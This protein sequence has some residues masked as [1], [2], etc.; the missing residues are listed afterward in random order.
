MRSLV[1][2]AKRDM[3]M[4][5]ACIAAVISCFIVPPDAQYVGYIDF[6]TLALLFC[7]MLVVAGFKH[8]GLFEAL[9]GALVSRITSPRGIALALVMLCFFGSTLITNDVSLITFVPFAMLVLKMTGLQ[10]Q[11]YLTVCLMTIAANLGSMLTPMGNP[12]N[13]YLYASSEYGLTDFILLMLPYFVAA[14]LLLAACTFLI[15]NDDRHDDT[16]TSSHEGS[17]D[18][19][20][21]RSL[22]DVIGV[23]L[24]WYAALF[25]LCLFAVAKVLPVWILLII[26]C[27]AIAMKRRSLLRNVDYGLLATFVFFFVFVGNMSRIDAINTWLSTLMEQHA[28]TVSILSSQVISNVPA[29]VLL[30]HY[31]SDVA[32][33]IIGTNLGGLGT[34]IASMASLISYKQIAAEYPERKGHY[35]LVFTVWNVIFLAVLWGMAL[36]L[37]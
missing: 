25:I 12:Q 24:Y 18:F 5:I 3:V 37:R 9:G 14:A 29:A 2:F 8:L 23:E 22:D 33:M 27:C 17:A 36:V 32:S 10:S 16:Y 19:M 6:H 30:S 15:R 31:T 7:L 13:L 21:A 20:E 1:E 4:T 34:L 11:V 28:L 26:V 35:M